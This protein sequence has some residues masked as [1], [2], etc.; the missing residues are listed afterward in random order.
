[1]AFA[2]DGPRREHF[3]RVRA[4]PGGPAPSET[5]KAITG[6]RS[7]LENDE[8]WWKSATSRLLEAERRLQRAAAGL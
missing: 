7:A 3:V 6:S 4:T 1:M 2:S 5:A 8:E